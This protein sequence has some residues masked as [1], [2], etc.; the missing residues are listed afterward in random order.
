MPDA[1]AILDPL[2]ASVFHTDVTCTDLWVLAARVEAASGAPVTDPE[3]LVDQAHA[4]GLLV[5]VRVLQLAGLAGGPRCCP[6]C[7]PATAADPL[8]LAA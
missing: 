5:P 4:D 6:G 1:F 8:P 2:D 7:R 3:A